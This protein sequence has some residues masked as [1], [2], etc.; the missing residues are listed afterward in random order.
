[1][2]KWNITLKAESEES[3]ISMLSI[4]MSAYTTA[5]EINEP[6]HFCSFDTDKKGEFLKCVLK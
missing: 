6:L 1:M 4:L 5:A 3:A 2:K